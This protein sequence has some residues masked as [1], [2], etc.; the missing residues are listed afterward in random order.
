MAKV[1]D[2]MVAFA[3]VGLAC[4]GDNGG[5]EPSSETGTD[6]GM[7]SDD[8]A[9]AP[10]PMTGADAGTTTT[11]GSESTGP[12]DGEGTDSGTNG[13][14]EGDSDGDSDTAGD[15]TDTGEDPPVCAEPDVDA[16]CDGLML[17]DD[18]G[19]PLIHARRLMPGVLQFKEEGY[20]L[21]G[22]GDPINLLACGECG[23]SADG[24]YRLTFPG[25]LAIGEYSNATADFELESASSE[26]LAG[27]DFCD[28]A[29]GVIDQA[30]VV[31]TDV[32]ESCAVGT[33]ELAG[34]SYR[35]AAVGCP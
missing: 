22:A 13:D 15:T 26:S 6:S 31:V 35:F 12:D 3:V 16:A 28:A 17:P 1:I 8:A 33:V 20:E 4:D 30:A 10:D 34:T 32:D 27:K 14:S 7:S 21:C 23:D 9:D 29:E 24:A 11:E 18:A 5:A 25:P 2:L 19:L